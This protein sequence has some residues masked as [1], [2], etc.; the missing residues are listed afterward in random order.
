M[1]GARLVPDAQNHNGPKWDCQRR[2]APSIAFIG[3]GV[4]LSELREM[5]VWSA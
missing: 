3:L 5:Q 1:Y 2:I 4:G